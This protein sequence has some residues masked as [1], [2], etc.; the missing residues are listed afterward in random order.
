MLF[1]NKWN[2]TIL[3]KITE[4]VKKCSLG[5]FYALAYLNKITYKHHSKCRDC[6]KVVFLV[7]KEYLNL[8]EYITHTHTHTVGFRYCRHFDNGN[9]V[10]NH[11]FFHSSL[12]N[13]YLNHKSSDFSTSILSGFDPWISNIGLD[14]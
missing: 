8:M 5:L 13:G 4:E 11:H 14:S 10:I 3:I 2:K 7:L 1:E 6:F 12:W 9:Q